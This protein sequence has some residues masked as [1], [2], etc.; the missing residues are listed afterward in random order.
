ML[1][2]EY[3]TPEKTSQE[4][5]KDQL[6]TLGYVTWSDIARICWFKPGKPFA[7][8]RARLAF[9]KD[10]HENWGS[11]TL[12]LV[13]LSQDWISFLVNTLLK[14]KAGIFYTSLSW[15]T[16]DTPWKLSKQEKNELVTQENYRVWPL[17]NKYLISPTLKPKLLHNYP[18]LFITRKYRWTPTLFIKDGKLEEFFQALVKMTELQH[19]AVI[20]NIKYKAPK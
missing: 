17:L 9:E 7:K 15:S 20:N 2:L 18:D 19:I 11:A 10:Y 6:A 14:D 5:L 8:F 13:K 1:F 3:S 12:P 16:E 4:K